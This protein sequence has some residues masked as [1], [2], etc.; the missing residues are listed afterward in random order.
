MVNEGGLISRLP[1]IRGK[2]RE[3]AELAKACWFQ[4]GGPAEV[5]F[6]PEDA[7]DL[8]HF[9]ADKSEDIP[10]TV[11]G[12][13]SNL[14]VR[15]GGIDGVVIR[16]GRGF[17]DCR[18]EDDRVIAGAGCLN[19]NVVIMAQQYG[20]SGLEFLSGIPGG[21]GGALAMNAGAYGAETK[22]ILIEAEVIDGDGKVHTVTADKLGYSYRHSSAPEEWIFTKAVL[23]GRKEKPAVIAAVIEKIAHERVSTQ[24]VRSRTGGST[25]KNPPEKKAWQLID[26]AGCRGLTVGGA[27]MSELHCNFMI[28]TGNATAADLETLGDTVRKRVFDYSGV[29]LEWEIKILGKKAAY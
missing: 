14:L 7:D 21:I 15:D 19:S 17:V 16:L 25:F 22:D 27:Q 3:N 26:E 28:N 9:I 6:R 18:V 24:P 5:L 11:L 2:L 4:V 20:I 23:Q 12:V 8:A 10:V 13:G 29:M 1:S